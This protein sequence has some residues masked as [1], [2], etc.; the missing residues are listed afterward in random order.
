MARTRR[1]KPRDRRARFQLAFAF[2]FNAWIPAWFNRSIFQGRV[3]GTCVPVLNCYSC[4]SAIGA[5]P[6]GALQM[7][8]ADMR[9][10][11]ALGA[12]KFGLYVAGFLGAVGSI[13]GRIPCGWA[14]PFGFI[15]ELLWKAPGPKIKLP[16]FLRYGRYVFLV[17]MV[18][19]LPLLILDDMGYGETWFCRWVCPAGTLEA[20]LPLVLLNK[21]LRSLIGFNFYF[22]VGLLVFFI[23][24]MILSRRPF[25]RAVC[26]LGAVL[27]MFNPASLFR[28]SVD[29]DK[30]TLCDECYRDCPVEIKIYQ[31]PNT[32]DCIRCL[33]CVSSCKFGAVSY[34]FLNKKEVAEDLRFKKS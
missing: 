9:A 3:K 11:L 24:V 25:C 17:L 27:G 34:E 18:I 26:P 10:G 4:P 14:C 12:R 16:R 29:I 15:Q 13:A 5:C 20:G 28:M 23:V 7:F 19:L 1:Y 33:K 31:A 32:S 22:K 30:C 2:I 8:F 6:I 21:N